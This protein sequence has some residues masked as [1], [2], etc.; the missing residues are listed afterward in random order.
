MRLLAVLACALLQATAAPTSQQPVFRSRADLVVVDVIAAGADGKA[1]LGLRAADFELLVDGK[2]TPI[3]TL[4]LVRHETAS[5]DA[6]ITPLVASAAGA[7]RASND[8][9]LDARII[10]IVLDDISLRF[11]AGHFN[12]AKAV[13]LS[14]VDRLGP[15]DQIAMVSTSRHSAYQI[16]FTTDGSRVRKAFDRMILS[17]QNSNEM[18]PDVL[19]K[20]AEQLVS[21]GPQ[22]KTVV[23]IASP[24]MLESVEY[25]RL[26]TAAQRANVALYTFDPRYSNDIDE[27]IHAETVEARA[28]QVQG[29]RAGVSTLRA[30]AE[31][32]G[33]LASSNTNLFDAAVG[34]MFDDT[35]AYYQLGFVSTV[36]K[37][38][39][40]HHIEVRA[41][42][43]DIRIRARQG[44][45]SEKA[46]EP[47]AAAVAASRLVDAVLAAPVQQ[48][49]LPMR[50]AAVTIPTADRRRSLVNWVT[51]VRSDFNAGDQLEIKALALDMTPLVRGSDTYVAQ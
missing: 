21:A 49:G 28:E 23:L 10:V 6:P 25:L 46:E 42:N 36:P 13:V 31:N 35:S 39:R 20:V 11:S 5:A 26:F 15:G 43:R 2:P 19:R 44:F 1:V 27:G 48:R 18:T 9:A 29:Y 51:E 38:G 47:G 7:A 37:D 24:G 17:E 3:E 34:R 22:R 4:N 30:L 50:F 33:G 12:R 40:L 16:E 8:R 14:I 41:R 32:T 45:V